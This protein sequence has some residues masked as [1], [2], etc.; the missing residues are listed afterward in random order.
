[1]STSNIL[2][3]AEAPEPPGDRLAPGLLGW[4]ERGLL[5]DGPLR[6]GIRRLCAQR[7]EAERVGGPGDEAVRFQQR[8][9]QLRVAEVA[10]HTDAA[11]AQH[12]ELPPAFF[13]RCLGRRLKYSCAYYPRGGESLDA[14]EEA[15]LSL[16][17]QRAQLADG[18]EILELGCGW[19]SLTLWMAE[20]YP[21]ARIC[22]VSNSRLQREHIERSCQAQGLR[23][24]RV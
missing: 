5:P 4:A 13:E 3:S 10:L 22:A 2:L 24:V 16:Y 15:M 18:Q 11:N 17:E 6:W 14:A 21:K 20:R 7:L 23:N 1:M 8:L 9:A 12:Y 19:G